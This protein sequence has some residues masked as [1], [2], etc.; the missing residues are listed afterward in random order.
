MLFYDY[1]PEGHPVKIY[2][3]EKYDSSWFGV[4]QC[5]IK[6]LKKDILLKSFMRKNGIFRE[7]SLKILIF[8][9]R[10]D[11]GKKKP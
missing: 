6:Q 5:K 3:P 8:A 1:L 11:E 2:N 4:V 9:R 10:M 7:C